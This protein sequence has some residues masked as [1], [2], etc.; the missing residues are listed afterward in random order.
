MML[1][2]FFRKTRKSVLPRPVHQ[3]AARRGG[4]SRTLLRLEALEERLTPATDYWTGAAGN[5]WNDIG[6]WRTAPG[7]G[8]SP[9]LPSVGDDL[10]FQSASAGATHLANVN[11]FPAGTEFHSIM[12]ADA[13]SISGNDVVLDVPGLTATNGASTTATFGLNV[14]GAGGVTVTG[15]GTL[16]LTAAG[17]GNSF[18]GNVA[19]TGGVLSVA[20]DANLGDPGNAVT[21]DGGTLAA[22]ASFASLRAVTL[23]A[24]NGTIDVTGGSTLTLA[25]AVGGSGGLTLTD[26][27]TLD[28][29]G[30]PLDTLANSYTG[31]TTVDGGTLVLAKAPSV[32]A[33]AGTTVGILDGGTLRLTAPNAIASGASVTLSS[34]ALDFSN[35][36]QV[37]AGLTMSGGTL[38]TSSSATAGNTIQ[39]SGTANITGGTVTVG[40]STSLF[41]QSMLLAA[42]GT[43]TVQGGTGTALGVGG[44]PLTLTG[45]TIT[46]N[47]GT[48]GA[49]LLLGGTVNTVASATPSRITA[50][51]GSGTAP[52]VDLLN[53]SVVFN[54][55][56]GSAPGQDL[57]IDTAIV[58][59]HIGK[60]GTG[61]LAL[62][63]T[64]TY[65]GGTDVA[66]GTLLV[67]APGSLAAAGTVNVLAGGTLAG[68]GTV[69]TISSVAGTI[70][71][72]VGG[73]GTLGAA[74]VTFDPSSVFA[75]AINGTA[76]G[77]GY[78]QL[79]AT[80]NVNLGGATLSAT[81]GYTPALGDSYTL[82]T[83]SGGTISGTFAGLPEGAN[84][85]VG[86]TNFQITYQASGGTA[87]VLTRVLRETV[88]FTSSDNPV[89]AGA[90]FAVTATI[91]DEF[92]NTVTGYTGTVHFMASNG[93]MVNYTFTAADMGT[94]TFN[95]LRLPRAGTVT[96]T[97]TDTMNPAITGSTSITVV[98]AAPDHIA[99]VLP[100]T[101]TAGQPFSVAVAVEDVFGN[102]VTDYQGT[103][104]F[105]L[106]GAGTAMVNYTFTAADM[107]QHTFNNVMLSQSGDYTLTAADTVNPD[108][109]GGI[110][111]TVT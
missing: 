58:N 52:V 3:R 89:V 40:S 88:T 42:P 37:L 98:A 27:G 21:L 5:L 92:G 109:N 59:G 8:G 70:S 78:D 105:M 50:S 84:V 53:T 9:V 107:G 29:G 18:T 97:G 38:T 66:A 2:S 103:V 63:G 99:L 4:P 39:I 32:T 85:Q 61:R 94:H 54:V 43:V 12:I 102:V 51:G 23:G 48:G 96:V 69:G 20:A 16:V 67:N 33:V 81:L 75:V 6:N 47:L 62:T 28:L 14:A 26:A 104:H 80:G 90:P 77:T 57:L 68:T 19:V 65:T 55:P 64:S 25:G 35:Q 82:I 71:P 60:L 56:L 95:G 73:P 87:V 72:G 1:P 110:D 76:A 41:A 106:T 24:G 46:L 31:P 7:T 83:T 86:G 91:Q 10:V 49:R 22:T 108:V 36:S 11:D 79:S 44:G 74:D 111:F 30:G 17:A 15:P 93:A 34:G 101:V 100:T 13:Y 45:A